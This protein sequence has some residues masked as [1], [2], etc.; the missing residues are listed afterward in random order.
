MDKTITNFNPL[1]SI[2][3]NVSLFTNELILSRTLS[4]H[5]EYTKFEKQNIWRFSLVSWT[6]ELEI[7]IKFEGP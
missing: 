1:P 3:Y 7:E 2:T 4:N 6:L 5:C